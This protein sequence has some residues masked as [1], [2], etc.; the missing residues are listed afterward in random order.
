MEWQPIETAPEEVPV[1]LWCEAE[2][3]ISPPKEGGRITNT[4]CCVVGILNKY[5]W[6]PGYQPQWELLLAGGYSEDDDI[7]PQ[8]THWMSLPE[9]PS[10]IR[11]DD[12]G[13]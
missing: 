11:G 12:A 5:H 1:L 7:N 4:G 3:T 6:S 2:W 13:T 9:R 8:P 10:E